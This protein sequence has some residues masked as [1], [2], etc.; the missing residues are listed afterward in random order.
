MSPTCG[1]RFV[2][3]PILLTGVIL[4]LAPR[5]QAARQEFPISLRK[6]NELTRLHAFIKPEPAHCGE[7]GGRINIRLQA[8]VGNRVAAH[9]PHTSLFTK[10]K[11]RPQLTKKSPLILIVTSAILRIA[12]PPRYFHKCNTFSA[13]GKSR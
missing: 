11:Y 5:I 7:A 6:F 3:K 10:S 2:D 13:R 9:S 1:L 12:I 4:G 8:S